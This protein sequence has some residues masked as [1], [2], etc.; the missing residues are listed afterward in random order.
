MCSNII[1]FIKASALFLDLKIDFGSTAKAIAICSCQLSNFKVSLFESCSF[2]CH[3]FMLFLSAAS[4]N[5]YLLEF[6]PSLGLVCSIPKALEC[7]YQEFYNICRP[8]TASR[9]IKLEKKVLQLVLDEWLTME[10]P[11][12]FYSSQIQKDVSSTFACVK[13]NCLQPNPSP[14]QLIFN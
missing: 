8:K 14:V 9:A 7:I 4:K 11:E 12:S 3:L 2:C 6:H 10:K 5:I 13:S 1:M